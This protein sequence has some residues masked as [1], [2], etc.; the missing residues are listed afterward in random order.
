MP[1]IPVALK[2]RLQSWWSM[3]DDGN[4]AIFEAIY[5]EAPAAVS[6]AISGGGWIADAAEPGLAAQLAADDNAAHPMEAIPTIVASEPVEVRPSHATLGQ[7]VQFSWVEENSSTTPIG[8]YVTDVYVQNLAGETVAS[9]RLAQAGLD[10]R[11]TVQRTWE[12]EGSQVA[13][14]YDLMVYMNAEGGDPGVGV[15]G[16]QGH[17]SATA[18]RLGIGSDEGQAQGQ[19]NQAWDAVVRAFGAAATASPISGAA[20]HVVEGLNWLATL[21]LDDVERSEVERVSQYL[22]A[23]DPEYLAHLDPDGLGGQSELG[24]AFQAKVERLGGAV[25]NSSSYSPAT[26]RPLLD[27][28]NAFLQ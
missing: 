16:P 1:E 22:G 25:V 9:A 15:A 18:A 13:G 26:R 19:D 4:H 23:L 6:R 3:L 21:Q 5:L 8:A 7:K 24:R 11:G 28:L 12:F 2:P 27:A 17:R 14:E 20:P 10:A